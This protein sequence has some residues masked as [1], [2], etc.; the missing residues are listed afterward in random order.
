MTTTFPDAKILDVDLTNKKIT[1]KILSGDIYKLYPGGSALGVYLLLQEMNPKTDPF[2]PDNLIIFSVS[3]FTGLPVSGTS[4]FTVTTKSPLTGGCGDAQAGGDFPAMLKAN[5]Y[6]SIIFRGK[7]ENPSYV[8]INRDSVEIKDAGKIWGKVTGDAEDIIKDDIGNDRIEIAQIGPAGENLVKYACVLNK[9]TRAN[10]RNGTGA[11]MGSKNLKAVVVQKQKTIMPF[12]KKGFESLTKSAG[13][14]ERI[15]GFTEG[16]GLH[17]TGSTVIPMNRSGFL[18]TRNY[19]QGYLEDAVKID[20]RTLSESGFLKGRETCY[21]CA[22]RCKRVVDIP[23][24]VDPRYG[25][26]EYETLATFGSY[27]GVTDLETICICNQLC[28]MYGLDTISTGATIAFAMD[29]YE[30]GILTQEKT[31]GLELKFGNQDILPILVEKIAKRE[32]L[33]DL[34]AEGSKIAADQLGEAAKPLFMGVKGQEFPA[35]MPQHKPGLG[36]VYAANPYGADHQTTEHDT[37]I[38]IPG[39]PFKRGTDLIGNYNHYETST[40]LDEN[41]IRYIFDGQCYYSTLNS[42]SLCTFA[43]GFAWQLYGPTK[44]VDLCKYG[45]GWNVTIKELLEIG[46]RCLNMMRQFNALEGFTKLD[47]KLPERVFNP[48]PEGPGKGTGINKEE[49]ANAQSMYYKI[50]GWDEKTGN[51]TTESLKRLELDWLL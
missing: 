11:V 9:L 43:W 3:P 10:G 8:Y 33:G 31:E 26:P 5:G 22:V 45:I 18:P 36:V 27:C 42:L 7:S 48:I 39:N 28:N 1:T 34:L 2:S 44:L 17:G 16:F 19:F 23:D 21:A 14:K 35:H 13:M 50:A 40:I 46:E 51:P 4:R 6:D 29:C 30:N 20:G 32:G 49:F 15:K 38:A 12:D 47:D 25:G 37:M 24:K 41:K